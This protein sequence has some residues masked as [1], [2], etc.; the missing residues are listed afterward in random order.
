M[1]RFSNQNPPRIELELTDVS[2]VGEVSATF[3]HVGTDGYIVLEGDG[4]GQTQALVELTPSTW[5]NPILPGK[6]QCTQ[7]TALD[8][9]GN[10]SEYTPET[11]P[12]L[13]NRS[14]WY[15]YPGGD[16]ADTEGPELIRFVNRA[17]DTLTAP[18]RT[19]D[20]L[21]RYAE[22]LGAT[23]E[24]DTSVQQAQA[25]TRRELSGEIA[26]LTDELVETR[27]AEERRFRVSVLLKIISIIV[28]AAAMATG[29]INVGDIDID[30]YQ[31]VKDTKEQQ[32]SHY[33]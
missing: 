18:E 17:I 15:E 22:I 2:G 27:S 23:I 7:I 6:Y 25:A 31:V 1:E 4:G 30:A 32:S 28:T 14:F 29:G 3:D 9:A 24:G 5:S 20:E 13:V 26:R 10:L 11:H 12:H 19:T 8:G 33:P 16:A 21:R